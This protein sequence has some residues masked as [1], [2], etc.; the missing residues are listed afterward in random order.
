MS[1]IFPDFSID[2]KT[3]IKSGL[4]ICPEQQS[5]QTAA[6]GL[7][8]R[9]PQWKLLHCAEY[10]APC[11]ACSHP[12]ISPSSAPGSRKGRPLLTWHSQGGGSLFKNP[13]KECQYRSRAQTHSRGSRRNTPGQKK[14]HPVQ[15]GW[16]H[17]PV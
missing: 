5:W 9:P 10:S 7:C 8:T 17:C 16:C 14:K 3:E 15:G 13:I 4:L 6:L 1:I 11:C 12:A 2:K